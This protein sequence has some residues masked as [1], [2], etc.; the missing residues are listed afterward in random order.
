MHP[1]IST[2]LFLQQR[3][4]PALL[5]TLH[6]AGAQ[7]IEIFA[8]RHHFDYTDRAAV[9]EIANWFRSNQVAASLHMP[10]FSFDEEAQW[11]RHTSPSLNLIDADKSAR[12]ET[13]D[14][15]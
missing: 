11:S 9:R 15:V 2:H 1:A 12:I 14:E 7:G 8:A 10:L 5:D 3:L 13:M 6:G 4:T